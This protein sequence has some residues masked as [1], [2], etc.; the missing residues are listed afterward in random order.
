MYLCTP[1]PYNS[2]AA[3]HVEVLHTIVSF[4]C[5]LRDYFTSSPIK[6]TRVLL[7][8]L[9]VFTFFSLCLFGICHQHRQFLLAGTPRSSIS[10][11]S[12]RQFI[13]HGSDLQRNIQASEI[14]G[15]LA[16][17][18]GERARFRPEGENS[19][20]VGESFPAEGA[21]VSEKT[22]TSPYERAWGTRDTE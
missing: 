13:D 7:Q 18:P 19:P 21:R 17:V 5:A 6:F 11:S 20:A 10:R 3:H 1:Y 12:R 15:L 9:G 22:T 2:E 8:S 4:C 16:K 14:P